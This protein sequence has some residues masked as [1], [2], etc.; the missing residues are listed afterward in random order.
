M[1]A[2]Q[3][4][5]TGKALPKKLVTND[6]MSK[7]VDTSDEWISTRTG[8][9]QNT[10]T[11]PNEEIPDVSATNNHSAPQTKNETGLIANKTPNNAEIPLPPLKRNQIG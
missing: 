5:A 9:K 2:I 3:I 7:I 4:I 8:I 10:I 6:D 11:A 1:D